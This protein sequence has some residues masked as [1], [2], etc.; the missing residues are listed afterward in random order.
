MNKNKI[1]K[2]FIVF[3]VLS[4]ILIWNGDCNSL[5]ASK[6]KKAYTAYEK[7]LKNIYS[8]KEFRSLKNLT[9]GDIYFMAKD[10]SGDKIPELIIRETFTAPNEYYIYTYKNGK[11]KKLKTINYYKGGELTKI[12]PSKH[13]LSADEGDSWTHHLI[14]YRVQH[15][16]IKIIARK[17]NGKYYYNGKVVSKKTY[18]KFVK[19]L[20]KTKGYSFDKG[21]YAFKKNTSK[22]RKK[23]LK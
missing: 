6:S 17:K 10:I 11:V 15:G 21:K 2:V 7:F 12:Y 14:Y 23:Y 18:D 20:K 5:A 4:M 16:K 13:I 19:K 22:N 3:S 1:F 9:W 8:K